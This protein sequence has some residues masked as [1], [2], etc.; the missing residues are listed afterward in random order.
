MT[1]VEE[2]AFEQMAR[3]YQ[4]ASEL[5]AGELQDAVRGWVDTWSADETT[6]RQAETRLYDLCG[7]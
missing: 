3:T 5:P 4:I 2:V 6:R 7:I 1:D